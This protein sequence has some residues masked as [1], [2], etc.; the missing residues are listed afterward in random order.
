MSDAKVHP[1]TKEWAERAYVD[2]D[3]YRAMYERSIG[4]PDGFWAE[5]AQRIDWITPFTRVKNTAI[6]KFLVAVIVASFRYC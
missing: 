6:R 4:D 2:A 1:V 3:T 5:Q